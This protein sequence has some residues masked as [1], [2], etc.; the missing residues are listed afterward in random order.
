MVRGFVVRVVVRGK[1]KNGERADGQERDEVAGSG[2]VRMPPLGG[3]E[4]SGVI[5]RTTLSKH[6]KHLYLHK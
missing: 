5:V 2:I 4:E 6:Q 1:L 3:L